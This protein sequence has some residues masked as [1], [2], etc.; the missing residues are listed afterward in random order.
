MTKIDIIIPVKNE[1]KNVA[2]LTNRIFDSMSN[3]NDDY[4]VLYIVDPST[5]NTLSE[6]EN[7]RRQYKNVY[8]HL[9]QGRPGKAFSIIEGAQLSDADY[10]AMI[11]G[12]LQ[13][14]P[15]A[16]TEMI[17]IA[18]EKGV[19]VANRVTHKTS[20]LR[21]FFSKVNNFVFGKVLLGLDCDVQSGLKVFKREIFT[22]LDTKNIKPWAFDMPLLKTASDLG[23][24]IGE[25][26]IDFVD[27]TEGQSKVNFL[28]TSF[29]VALTAIS[30]KFKQD[31]VYEHTP[32]VNNPLGKGLSYKKN[33][34]ITHTGLPHEISAVVTFTNGQKALFGLIAILVFLGIA[35]SP[36]TTL[37]AFIGILTFIYFLDMLFSIYVLIKS[38]HFP[39]ELAFTSEEI[40]EI[41][42]RT[43][44]KYSILIPMYKEGEVLAELIK[45]IDMLDWPKNRLEVLLLLEEDDDETQMAAKKA[46]LP[47]YMRVLIVPHSMPKTKPKACNY[48][49][50]HTTGQFVVVYDAE[51]KPD[52]L[53]LKKVYLGFKK[54]PS[55]VV[56]L[57]SKLNYF[58]ASQNWLTRLFTA[59]YSLWFDIILPG[60]Q[61]IESTIPLG[62]TSNHF[63]TKELKELHGWDAFNVT[64]DCDL[65][66]R[67]FKAGYKTSIVDSTTLEEANSNV[68]NW[69]RQ[70]SRWI[71]G[72][73]QTYLV[74]MREPVRFFR[75][76]GIHAFTFQLIIGM[77][78]SFMVINPFLWATTIA[79]FTA[80]KYVG[81]AIESLYPAWIFYIAA[82]TLT[83]GNFLYIYNY[84]I[85]CAK[86]GHYEL[87]KF[88]FLIPIYWIMNSISAFIAFYQLIV[89]PHYW[90][91]TNHGL[92]LPKVVVEVDLN[93]E[94]ETASIPAKESIIKRPN[95]LKDIGLASGGVLI[96]SSGLANVMNLGYNAFLGRALPLEEFG[97]IAVIGSIFSITGIATS[98]IGRA[99][100]F[101]SAYLFGKS[102]QTFKLFWKK[103]RMTGLG[104][105]VGMLLIW[106]ASA[107]LLSYI[108]K[109]DSL[110]P[111][112]LFMPVWPIVFVTSV[113][114]GFLRGNIKFNLLA[115]L[116]LIET[117]IKFLSA[118][119]LVEIGLGEYV[120]A[121][122]PIGL[123]ASFFAGWLAIGL[124]KD[125][126]G[127]STVE[128]KDLAFPRMFFGTSILTKIAVVLFL[129]IDVILAK[130][131]LSPTEAGQYALLSLSGKIVFFLGSLFSEFIDPLISKR[132]GEKK[133]TL[134][135]FYAILAFI[136]LASYSGFVAF[137]LMGSITMPLVFGEKA[138][139]IVQYLPVYTLGMASLVI[140]LSIVTY[141]QLKNNIYFP[142]LAITTAVTEIILIARFGRDIESFTNIVGFLGVTLFII[143]LLSHFVSIYLRSLSENTADLLGLFR[144]IDTDRNQK[145][146]LDILI[147]NWRDTKHIWAG[148][149]EEYVQS[150]A[151][152]WAQ[153]GHNVT[154]FCG[155]D[156]R[157]PRNQKI[158]NINIIRRGGLY[159]VYI[160]AFL[161]YIIH[162]R[163]KFDI[164][165]E[166]MNGVPFFTPLYSNVK[167]YLIIHHVHQGVFRNYLTFPLDY[168]AQFIE[169]ILTPTF[170]RNIK[171][172]T[173]SE[174]SKVDITSTLGIPKDNIY[175]AKP[176]VSLDLIGRSRK[177][178]YP[179]FIYLGRH[180]PYKNIDKAIVA[181]S[182]LVS[183]IPNATFTIAGEGESTEDLKN[184]VK[185]LKLE[186][187][188]IFTGKVSEYEKKSLFGRSWAAV[189]V[190]S[191]EGW[192]ITVIEANATGT[193]VIASFTSGLKDSVLHNETGLL[194][195]L[196]NISAIT[197]AMM[198][199]SKNH[200]LRE[201]LSKNAYL[202]AKKFNWDTT[203]QE[204]LEIFKEDINLSEKYSYATV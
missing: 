127:K 21:K 174:S 74:H 185:N 166:S 14:P 193:P 69:L 47:D 186:H 104:V 135:I 77:R 148:G 165:V 203:S 198:L 50:A 60:L 150:I 22:H 131:F 62:G 55:N 182:K 158:N 137:G 4:R 41:D 170:Y 100:T 118:I 102:G 103:M 38:L 81:P 97:L 11:D 8:I 125:S 190:S 25:F 162:F 180:K 70:R 7:V 145:S 140:A 48:G 1:E 173:V 113:D 78:I 134:G 161:Y 108:F 196:D 82:A 88:V 94:E 204:M 124:L 61:S 183:K 96:L 49:L 72:Y 43:L 181:F 192:G 73:L 15:E 139:D 106:I 79:Y 63:R 109:S 56:C 3:S 64:E 71:K 141:H 20:Y 177:T 27:R 92:H 35:L 151:E 67:L 95:F 156:G 154:I 157:S 175:V 89:K 136:S 87:I 10:L 184:L 197:E 142:I 2:K 34:F 33:K 30:L 26:D 114:Q 66:A 122:P 112:M 201:R 93:A 149:S 23:Y 16:L 51:D 160:W 29:Q 44:P 143:V 75:S 28:S 12:D 179:S 152:N 195:E 17:E 9:K 123:I 146:G 111:F 39:P 133:D 107:P 132:I 80:Y 129:G 169:K 144:K 171:I 36:H 199:I 59:E 155:N 90:E 117:S 128:K 52:P 121:A 65:G 42:D 31:K 68:K 194:V 187:N 6:L 168:I 5:D 188:V 91:K 116:V 147:F 130:Y 178:A 85:G 153:E 40:A 54:L 84:M 189:Q 37:L 105:G 45:N 120:Y 18:K 57:Q 164:L 176:G 32:D 76:H 200:K 98:S 172:F 202:W 101:K 119:I 83:L 58:N 13:Y 86:R 115:A 99:V 19:A 24:E 53:Q 191:F 159:T 110:V 46:D 163:N 126:D 138:L 167:K